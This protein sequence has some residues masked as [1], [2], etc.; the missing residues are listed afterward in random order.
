MGI[1]IEKLDLQDAMKLTV[2]V[3]DNHWGRGIPAMAESILHDVSN[4]T[5]IYVAMDSELIIG[6]V[7]GFVSGTRALFPQFM[8]I[9]EAYRG[10]K[11]G[12]LLMHE[13]ENGS[14]CSVSLIYYE[15][16]LHDYYK[17]QKYVTGDNLEAAIKTIG[18]PQ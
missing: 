11:I 9:K 3:E 4:T 2:L 12:S 15:S 6:F 18:E 10:Q 16:H 1:N 17:K 14:G 8:Y 13:M 7:Y 5:I